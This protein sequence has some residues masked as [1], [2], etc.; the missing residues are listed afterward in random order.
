MQEDPVISDWVHVLGGLICWVA[1][2]AAGAAA[3]GAQRS[4]GGGGTVTTF[5]F[6]VRADYLLSTLCATKTFFWNRASI[7]PKKVTFDRACRTGSEKTGRA[8]SVISSRS[9]I[10]YLDAGEPSHF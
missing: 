4:V 1:R 3:G 8:V 6:P 2:K 10:C 5:R 9:S 7:N